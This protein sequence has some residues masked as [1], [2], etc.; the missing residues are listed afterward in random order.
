[1]SEQQPA[2]VADL[3]ERRAELTWG[4]KAANV[5]AKIHRPLLLQVE[6][7]AKAKGMSV[8]DYVREALFE[9]IFNDEMKAIDEENKV[10]ARETMK[11]VRRQNPRGRS[12]PPTLKEMSDKNYAPSNEAYAQEV[13][14]KAIDEFRKGRRR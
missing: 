4:P 12:S 10:F 11:Q 13:V 7:V 3:K 2:V 14:E 5:F 1:M 6:R 8:A 9:K